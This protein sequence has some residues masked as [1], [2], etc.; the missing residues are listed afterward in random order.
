MD[1]EFKSFLVTNPDILDEGID[2]SG[3]RQATEQ[4]KL[5]AGAIA[6]EPGLAYDPRL[7]SYLSDLNRYFS[8]G[9]PTIST[10]PTTTPTPPTGGDGGGG[11]D[12]GTDG[13][14]GPR[15]RTES[16]NPLT[17]M[18]TTPTGDT[19]TAKQAFTDDDAYSLGTPTVQPIDNTITIENIGTTEIDPGNPL[20]L[21]DPGETVVAS[22]PVTPIQDLSP[23]K[24]IKAA[25]GN[26]YDAVTGE[27]VQAGTVAGPFD[28][29]QPS[30]TDAERLANYTPSFENIEGLTKP[31]SN[32]L[33]DIASKVGGDL[34]QFGQEIASIP[35]AVYDSL[36]NTVEVFGQ[37]FNIGKT[38]AGL[39]MNKIAGGPVSLLF[40]IIQKIASALPEQ[41]IQT[42]IV[43]ELKREKDY[44]Y[45]VTVGNLNVDPFGRNPVS[46]FGD[47]EKALTED[48]VS[49]DP[50]PF[51]EAKKEFAQDYFNRKAEKAGG[52]EVEEGVVMGP[53]EA[54]PEDG[55]LTTFQ[56]LLD[57]RDKEREDALT[58]AISGDIGVEGEDEGRFTDRG[59][60]DQ[61]GGD[62]SQNE[63]AGK[64]AEDAQREAIQDAAR[65]GMSVN[66]A[67]ASVGM[68][69]NL[70]DTGGGKG[71]EGKIVCT[72]MNESYGFGSFRN[73]IW[74]KFHKDLSPEYQKGYHKLFLPLVKIAKKNKIVKKVLEHIAVHSTIDMR[75][76][77]RGKTHLLGRVYRKILLPLCYWV[78]KYVK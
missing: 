65:T 46:G 33:R 39:V 14:S 10:P 74:M 18:V 29:L 40:P 27:L 43:D 4:D 54:L 45:N 3:I 25:D 12:P 17:Q 66:Q 58:D 77:T 15:G 71:N 64:A 36:S 22:G 23:V 52:V 6:E 13:G 8:G 42:T 59:M 70:G 30:T 73:K 68:P 34:V 11:G 69:E 51:T 63:A 48:L 24:T 5:I 61:S 38:A 37:K 44:G 55:S 1:E 75:Q 31:Q 47:Y 53:G 19:M 26:T 16:V 2:V 56:D 20:A 60:K 62:T 67:K 50:S 78:G 7:T 32:T 9:F 28:Y 57:Q 49:T 76:A 35:G 21:L 41:A 72:M